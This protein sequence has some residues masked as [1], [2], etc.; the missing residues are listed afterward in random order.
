V[1]KKKVDIDVEKSLWGLL[2]RRIC[3][4]FGHPKSKGA[5]FSKPFIFSSG[6]N[7]T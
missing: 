5:L 7:M 4:V 1:V 3:G 6:N 2:V